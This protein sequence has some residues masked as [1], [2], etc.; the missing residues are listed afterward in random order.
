MDL[1]V[2]DQEQAVY[3]TDSDYVAGRGASNNHGLAV[4]EV[5]VPQGLMMTGVNT[6][7]VTDISSLSSTTTLSE[8]VY[9]NAQDSDYN[10]TVRLR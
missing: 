4:I 2:L 6:N 8:P 5:S 7:T 3:N 9:L 10:V 1:M